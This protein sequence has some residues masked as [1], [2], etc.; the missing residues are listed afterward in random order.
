MIEDREGNDSFS[1]LLFWIDQRVSYAFTAAFGMA[2]SHFYASDR[3]GD[4]PLVSAK[5][6]DRT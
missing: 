6:N 5:I 4:D 2:N 3:A 1:L